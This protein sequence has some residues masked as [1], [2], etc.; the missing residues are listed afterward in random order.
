MRPSGDPRPPPALVSA[1]VSVPAPAER[2]KKPP[3]ARRPAVKKADQSAALRVVMLAVRK[4][5]KSR[6]RTSLSAGAR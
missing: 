6:R 3:A 2:L 5:M 4:K 1:P